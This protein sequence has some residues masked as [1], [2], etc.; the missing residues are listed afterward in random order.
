MIRD[1]VAVDEMGGMAKDGMTPWFIPE[2]LAYF[3]E[4]SRR[5]GGNLLIGRGTYQAMKKG[6]RNVKVRVLGLQLGG[7]CMC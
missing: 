4:Q 5:F 6:F 1:I 3:H 2:D 7:T